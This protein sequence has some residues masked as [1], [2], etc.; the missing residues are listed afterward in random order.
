M[1]DGSLD[2]TEDSILDS[3]REDYTTSRRTSVSG[4]LLAPQDEGDD[5]GIADRLTEIA[6]FHNVQL[7]TW[8]LI[9]NN[10]NRLSWTEDS[11]HVELLPDETMAFIGSYDI[12]VNFGAI[13]VHGATLK[14]NTKPY[15]VYAPASHALPIIRCSPVGKANIEILVVNNDLKS[16]IRLSPLFRRLWNKD[17]DVSEEI[18][19]LSKQSCQFVSTVTIRLCS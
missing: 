17:K 15:R 4:D 10:S 19:V 9:Y 14:V 13:T 11:I 6:H 5:V 12:V 1:C 2:D 16:M 18:K 3:D 8:K 7:S